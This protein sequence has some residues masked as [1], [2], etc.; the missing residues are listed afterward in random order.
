M[1]VRIVSATHKDLRQ[2]IEAGRFREDLFYRLNIVEILV[3]SLRERK[4]D[5]PLLAEALLRRAVPHVGKHLSGF[6]PIALEVLGRHHWPGNIRELHNE[7]ERAAIHAE[8]AMVDACDLNPR[9]GVPRPVP[10]KAQKRSLAEQFAELE[11]MEKM[12]VEQA[13]AEARGNISE[14][15]RLLGITRIMIKRRMERLGLTSKDD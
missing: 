15:A 10:G 1:D 12:L 14:A 5:I 13:L 9:L 3:P 7:V 2:E 8:G 4:D 11:P 6:T